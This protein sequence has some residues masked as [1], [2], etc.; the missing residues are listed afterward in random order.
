MKRYAKIMLDADDG[1]NDGYMHLNGTIQE[2]IVT[3][4]HRGDDVYISDKGEPGLI[5]YP[6]EYE[7]ISEFEYELRKL[8][9]SDR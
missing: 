4:G 3:P 9:L 1:A 2:I 6:W 7:E 5:L 8:T